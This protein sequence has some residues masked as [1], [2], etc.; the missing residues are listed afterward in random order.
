MYAD[1]MVLLSSSVCEM[2]EMINICVAEISELDL[3]FNGS[4]S[5]L[6]RF[7]VRYANQCA[8]VK[9]EGNVISYA[10]TAKYLDV[11]LCSGKSFNVD[12]HH[13]KSD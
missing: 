9:L 8:E 11:L 7:G 10:K 3:K 6:L 13:A 5:C 2:Q 1:D 4:K 12:I